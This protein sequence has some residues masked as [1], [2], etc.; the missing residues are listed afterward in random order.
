MEE[1]KWL[2]KDNKRDVKTISILAQ[3]GGGQISPSPLEK[4]KLLSPSPHLPPPVT[5]LLHSPS[6]MPQGEGGGGPP[7]RGGRKKGIC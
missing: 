4:E 2:V 6:S 7:M 1:W 5:S 3:K